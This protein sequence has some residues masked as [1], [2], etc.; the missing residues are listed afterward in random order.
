MCILLCLIISE[1][2]AYLLRF[3]N[4]LALD[5]PNVKFLRHLKSSSKLKSTSIP[6]HPSPNKIVMKCIDVLTNWMPLAKIDWSSITLH[7]PGLD[8]QQGSNLFLISSLS[9][10]SNSIGFIGNQEKRPCGFHFLPVAP[11]DMCGRPHGSSS[12][13]I[14]NFSDPT[15]RALLSFIRH[16]PKL[17]I[18][19]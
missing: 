17:K 12:G 2:L 9:P 15:F 11:I 7:Q 18:C 14:I 4:P 1:G 3:P 5:V 10:P 19:Q 16:G 8:C 13:F 6:Y